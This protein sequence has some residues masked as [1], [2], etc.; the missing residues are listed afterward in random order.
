M[1][2]GLA[3][4]GVAAK[5]VAVAGVVAGA[6]AGVVAGVVAT[7]VVVVL[8]VV[9]AVAV[10][11]VHLLCLLNDCNKSEPCRQAVQLVRGRVNRVSRAKNGESERE[12]E[13]LEHRLWR[14]RRSRRTRWWSRRNSRARAS[15]QMNKRI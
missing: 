3:A 7:A 8:V 6:V 4:A 11:V 2:A 14:E 9:I 5:A 1:P 13:R 12:R 10:V 15:R